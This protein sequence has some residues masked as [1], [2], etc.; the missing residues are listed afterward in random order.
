M[1]V[2]D[3][4]KLFNK[5]DKIST[6]AKTRKLQREYV[7]LK[8][9]S[10]LLFWTDVG[11]EGANHVKEQMRNREIA[12]HMAELDPD[13]SI[14]R[15]QKMIKQ[16][17]EVQRKADQAKRSRFSRGDNNGSVSPRISLVQL[18]VT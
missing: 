1:T 9:L 11:R 5:G 2:R 16:S 4:S 15:A 8:K 17:I 10:H 7:A 14:E 6:A 13:I 18:V 3:R 12:E